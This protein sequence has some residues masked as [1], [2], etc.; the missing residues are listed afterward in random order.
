MPADIET[1][2]MIDIY[3]KNGE[4]DGRM[5][6][7]RAHAG[8][9]IHHTVRV[10]AVE[11]GMA[12]FQRRSDDKLLFPGKL[13]PCA[14]GHVGA[15]ESPIGAAV[16]ELWE[17][18]RIAAGLDSLVFAGAVPLPI[19]RPDGCVD[20]ETAW[21]YLYRIRNGEQPRASDE[22]SG[23]VRIS[24]EDY[25]AMLDGTG[26]ILEKSEFCVPDGLEFGL[27]RRAMDAMEAGRR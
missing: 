4:R 26:G 18:T 6:R 13:D 8:G 14:T 27:V 19:T 20:D 1:K 21:V 11:D 17:E 2:E 3:K 10:W 5:P 7:S 22:A 12:W 16:R 24:L 23:F 9:L 15:G 25:G